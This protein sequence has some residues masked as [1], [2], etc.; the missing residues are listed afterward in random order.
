MIGSIEQAILDRLQAAADAGTLGYAWGALASYGGELDEDVPTL[1]TRGRFPAAWAVFAGDR[2]RDHPKGEVRETR[3]SLIVAARAGRN[4][5]ERRRGAADRVGAYQLVEDARA[6]LAG[7]T[8]GLD[9]EP[10]TVA[11]VRTLFNGASK[12]Q[13]LAVYALDLVTGYLAEAPVDVDVLDD[14]TTFHADWDIPPHGNVAAPLP[15]EEADAT[16]TITLPQ[17]GA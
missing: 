1:L 2:R 15:A 7:Q 6:L 13:R 14:F 11:G 12:S 8:L 5:A 9:I 10:I 16:D 3:F 17:E 4:E